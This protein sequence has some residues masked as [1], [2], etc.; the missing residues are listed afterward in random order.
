MRELWLQRSTELTFVFECLLQA[1]LCA[2][3][4]SGA[5]LAKLAETFLTASIYSR[6]ASSPILGQLTR[7]FREHT[8]TAE[9]I[10]LLGEFAFVLDTV[11]RKRARWLSTAVGVQAAA[12][13]RRA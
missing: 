9:F 10:D 11:G 5:T 7:L 8:L 2:L 1:A 6:N 13:T 4:G 12:W 3:E